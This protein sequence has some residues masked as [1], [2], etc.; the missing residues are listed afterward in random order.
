M[1]T[2]PLIISDADEVLVQFMPAFERYADERGL[3]FSLDSFALVGNIRH[4]DSAKVLDKQAVSQ[5][6]DDFF[7]E[8]VE[9]CEPVEGAAQTLALLA[10]D[11]DIVILTN[12]PDAQRERRE[13]A[14][15]SH[16]MPYRV[17][18]N[19]GP[20]GPPVKALIEGRSG[21]VVFID[22]LPPHHQSVAQTVSQVHRLHMIADAR[23]QVLIPRAD[24]AHARIDSWPEALPWLRSVLQL[25]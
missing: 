1:T 16:G 3:L 23:L 2:R 20:K 18:T 22:D 5:L 19:K 4:R 17:Y 15:A 21:P 7:E 9:H 25:A 11:A 12:I 10:R 8:R 14:L 13:R 24:H 6:I